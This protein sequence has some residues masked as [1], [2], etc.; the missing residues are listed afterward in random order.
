VFKLIIVFLNDL[1][2]II[3]ASLTGFMSVGC[4][5]KRVPRVEHTRTAWGHSVSFL[6]AIRVHY[7]GATNPSRGLG[8]SLM[9]ASRVLTVGPSRT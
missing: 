6:W 2:L 1:L 9:G 3:G 4:D 5:E 8:V 7:G